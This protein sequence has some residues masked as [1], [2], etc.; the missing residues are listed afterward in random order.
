MHE[1]EV[2]EDILKTPMMMEDVDRTPRCKHSKID[3]KNALIYKSHVFLGQMP[4]SSSK[5]LLKYIIFHDDLF[6]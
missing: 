2:I 1:S 4:I 3:Q 6:S 5:I